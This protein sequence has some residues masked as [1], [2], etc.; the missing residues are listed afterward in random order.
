MSQSVPDFSDKQIASV[1]AM[2]DKMFGEQ[3]ELQLGDG[4][5]L[6]DA[7]SAKASLCPVIYWQAQECHFLVFRVG[8]DQ[9]RAQYFYTPQDQH[10]TQQLDFTDVADCVTV[11]LKEQAKNIANKQD[12]NESETVH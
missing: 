8:A 1:Q 2:V 12:N 9:Y 7:E 10:T 3:I 4:D 5:I 11:L 6:V